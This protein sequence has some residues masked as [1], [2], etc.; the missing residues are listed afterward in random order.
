MPDKSRECGSNGTR[1]LAEVI[2]RGAPTLRR[3]Q[4]L[5]ERCLESLAQVARSKGLQKSVVLVSQYRPLWRSLA[6]QACTRASNMPFLLMDVHFQDVR[7]WRVAQSPRSQRRLRAVRAAAFSGRAAGGLMR[8]TLML[9]WNTVLLDRGAAGVLFGIAPDVSGIIAEL[10]PQDIERIA[11]RYSSH[12]R[13]RWEDFPAFWGKLLAVA[14]AGDDDGLH[15]CRLHGVQLIGSELLP[16][17][18]GGHL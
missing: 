15:E 7:W 2:W 13:P 4:A 6:G 17:L 1:E 5:N 18:A 11:S 9:S 14:C 16:V 10:G 3:I 8:E 12:L